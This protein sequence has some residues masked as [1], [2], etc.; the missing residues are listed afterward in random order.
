MQVKLTHSL[1]PRK[2]RQLEFWIRASHQ[3]ITK[4]VSLCQ[5]LDASLAG[6]ENPNFS[7]NEYK[8]NLV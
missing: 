7:T 1:P 6:D 2:A 3:I 4:D 8:V 5:K